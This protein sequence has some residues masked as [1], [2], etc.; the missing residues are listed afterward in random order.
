[1]NT[2]A[3]APDFSKS[4]VL[5]EVKSYLYTNEKSVMESW[6]LE[7]AEE[8][9]NEA[10]NTSFSAAARKLGLDAKPAGPFILNYGKPSFY[11]YGQQIG[12]FQEPY[13]S[14]ETSSSV[15]R[16]MKPFSLRSFLPPKTQSPN[17]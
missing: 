2:E 8:F 5:D 6:A 11:F 16:K 10:T 17:L 14:L 1:V 9:T 7:K 15:Q 3:S 12:L 4:S 13:R